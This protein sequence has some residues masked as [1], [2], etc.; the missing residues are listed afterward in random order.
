MKKALE[1][2]A[3]IATILGVVIALLA[4][5]KP[6]NPIGKSPVVPVATEGQLMPPVTVVAPTRLIF[7]STLTLSAINVEGT[8]ILDLT[9]AG[10][11]IPLQI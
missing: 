11:L 7:T 9:Y 8:W 6:F 5:L 3:A 2:A 1:V 4:W 10:W